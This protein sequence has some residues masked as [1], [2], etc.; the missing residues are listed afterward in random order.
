MMRCC[1]DGDN[2]GLVVIGG[3]CMPRQDLITHASTA[4]AAEVAMAGSS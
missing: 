4:A 3:V 1:A 2:S